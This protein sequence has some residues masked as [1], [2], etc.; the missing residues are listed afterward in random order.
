MAVAEVTFPT[1]FSQM[2]SAEHRAIRSEFEEKRCRVQ[3]EQG[4]KGHK[5]APGANSCQSFVLVQ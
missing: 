5:F 2:T 3:S 4:A 1:A